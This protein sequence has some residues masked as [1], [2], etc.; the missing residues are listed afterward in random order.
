MEPSVTNTTDT[1]DRCEEQSETA[2]APAPTEFDIALAVFTCESRRLKVA[3]LTV[4]EAYTQCLQEMARGFALPGL[5]LAATTCIQAQAYLIH[6]TT[7]IYAA[8]GAMRNL[9]AREEIPEFQKL[10]ELTGKL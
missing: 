4:S 8:T 2:E 7:G 6:V 3:A 5:R 1:D 10:Q 9:S